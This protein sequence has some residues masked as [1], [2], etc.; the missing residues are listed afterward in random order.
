MLF[1]AEAREPLRE[2]LQR[3]FICETIKSKNGE[4]LSGLE[5][6]FESTLSHISSKV[7]SFFY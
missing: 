3:R 2:K 6:K 1:T 5:I 7:F 4:R